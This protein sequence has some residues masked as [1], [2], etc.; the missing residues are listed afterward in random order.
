MIKVLRKL[1]NATSFSDVSR[2]CIDVAE[3]WNALARDR[4]LSRTTITT[5][6]L[7]GSNTIPHTLGYEP[8]GYIIAAKSAAVSDYLIS[9]SIDT[10]TI[11]ASAPATIT[12]EVF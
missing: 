4:F 8:S 7:A 1:A 6:V 11:N 5:Q 2:F 10:I 12:L 9:K 3:A